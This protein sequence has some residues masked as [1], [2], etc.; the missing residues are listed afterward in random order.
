MFNQREGGDPMSYEI[1]ALEE[2]LGFLVL[3]RETLG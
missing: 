3:V 2:G 1:T